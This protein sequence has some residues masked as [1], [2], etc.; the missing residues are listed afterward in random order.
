MFLF[1]GPR[2]GTSTWPLW[3]DCDLDILSGVL[4]PKEELDLGSER[5]FNPPETS[6]PSSSDTSGLVAAFF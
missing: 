6:L 4:G 3:C 2:G 5:C 1:L